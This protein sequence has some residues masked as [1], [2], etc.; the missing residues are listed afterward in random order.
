VIFCTLQYIVLIYLIAY[1]VKLN[2]TKWDRGT[3]AARRVRKTRDGQQHCLESVMRVFVSVNR[4]LDAA[5]IIYFSD[6]IRRR[7]EDCD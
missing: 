3:R 1:R 4:S 5:K 2:A 7:T 6:R